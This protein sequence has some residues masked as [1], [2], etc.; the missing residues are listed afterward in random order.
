MAELYDIDIS[1]KE[2]CDIAVSV[3]ADVPFCIHGGTALCEG[4]GEVLTPIYGMPE[5]VILVAKPDV[6][7][8]TAGIYKRLDDI[9]AFDHPDIDGLKGCIERC[10]AIGMCGYLGNV[11]EL[12]TGRE[13]R[14]ISVT[15]DLMMECGALGAMMTGS[16]PTV[17]GIFSDEDTAAACE[18][19]IRSE[20]LCSFLRLTGMKDRY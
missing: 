8:S 18:E 7:V 12:V 2:L 5:C 9:G 6:Q 11:L 3:G 13:V 17:F 14:D 19:R 15:E 16:G 4:I 1:E 20:G 10:D